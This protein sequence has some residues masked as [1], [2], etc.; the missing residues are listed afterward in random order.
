MDL[1]VSVVQYTIRLIFRFSLTD[2]KKTTPERIMQ[3]KIFLEN[4]VIT[5]DQFLEMTNGE[6]PIETIDESELL[7]KIFSTVNS[8]EHR[9]NKLES[10]VIKLL[11][12]RNPPS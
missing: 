1:V 7:L 9:I 12:E 5:E 4:G 11:T 3:A 2:P 6:S 8:I 10:L